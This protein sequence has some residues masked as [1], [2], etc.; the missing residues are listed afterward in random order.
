MSKV[1][2]MGNGTTTEFTF[3]FPYF[4]NSNIVVTKN[5]AAATGYSIVGNSE[6]ADANI[7]FAG[8]KVVFAAAPSSLDSITITRQLPLSR[9]TDYQP[10]ARIEP[11]ILNQDLNYLME[12]IKDRKDELEALRLQYADIADKESTDILLARMTAIH[13]EIAAISQQMTDFGD[14]SQVHSDIAA[15]NTRTNGLLDYVVASQLPSA[16]NGYLWYRKYKSGWIEQGGITSLEY[17]NANVTQEFCCNLV[18]PFPNNNYHLSIDFVGGY[19]ATRIGG[20]ESILTTNFK[21]FLK[22][23]TAVTLKIFWTA[24]GMTA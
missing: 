24:R 19:S 8:G 21:G 2:Y 7:P 17:T 18:L 16:A 13:N 5:G 15:L 1:S 14:L 20:V 6:G 22:Q 3:N 4:E 23:S 10:T 11:T 9:I 12:V